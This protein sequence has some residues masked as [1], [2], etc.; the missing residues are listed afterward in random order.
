MSSG[1]HTATTPGDHGGPRVVSATNEETKGRVGTGLS[2]MGGTG[3]EP[4]RKLPA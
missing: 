4:S 3:L 1:S 2:T